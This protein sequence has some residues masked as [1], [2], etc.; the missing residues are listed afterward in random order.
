MT[1]ITIK[2]F[3]QDLAAGGGI[4]PPSADCMEYA[5]KK[6][7]LETQEFLEKDKPL[8]RK[9]VARILH[10]F[11]R[12]E[13]EEPDEIDGSTAYGLQ[14]LFDCRVCAGHIIQVYVKGIMEGK[15][16][17]DGSFVFGSDEPVSKEEEKEIVRR[18]F[19]RTERFHQKAERNIIVAEPVQI[20]EEEAVQLYRDKNTILV[21]VRSQRDYEEYHVKGAISCPFL[22]IVKN[23]YR[24]SDS[25]HKAIACYCKEGYQSKVAAGYLLKAGYKKVVYFSLDIPK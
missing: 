6:G 21:D 5:C 19:H 1:E 2:E 9:E 14:D 18:L 10:M 8:K 15:R 7:W 12:K 3:V 23:P 17:E 16:R 11:L 25:K 4:V 24:F 20:T 13:L 22:E